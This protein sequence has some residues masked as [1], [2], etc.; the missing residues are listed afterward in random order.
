MVI[1]QF[2]AKTGHGTQWIKFKKLGRRSS[3]KTTAL[4]RDQ[5]FNFWAPKNGFAQ[6]HWILP[7]QRAKHAEFR[8]AG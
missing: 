5:T 8:P 2:P 3:T 6:F 1:I 4:N 7:F